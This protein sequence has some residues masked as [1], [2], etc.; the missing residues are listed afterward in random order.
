ME[1]TI[2]APWYLVAALTV[3]IVI[4]S[5]SETAKLFVTLS[6]RKLLKDSRS[7]LEAQIK[8]MRSEL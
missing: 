6:T 7:K 8:A 3:L 2:V 4:I 5:A 1:I